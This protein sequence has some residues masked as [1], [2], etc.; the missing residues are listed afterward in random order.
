LTAVSGEVCTEM[1][2]IPGSA[3][4]CMRIMTKKTKNGIVLRITLKG[5][6]VLRVFSSKIRLICVFCSLIFLFSFGAGCSRQEKEEITIELPTTPVLSSRSRWAVIT[7]SHLRLRDRATTDSKAITTLWRGNVL[8]IL[9]RDET[10][11]RVE[12]K[13]DYWYQ[14]AYDGLQGWVFGAYIELY[15]SERKAEAASKELQEQ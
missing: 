15:E 3:D 11:V 1:E 6:Y 12:G 7:G 13:D 10:K 9:A 2:T 4:N 5:S 14:V 8:E